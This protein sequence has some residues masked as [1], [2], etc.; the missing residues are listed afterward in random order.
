MSNVEKQQQID[1]LWTERQRQIEQKKED[2]S[3]AKETYKSL[4]T[5]TTAFRIEPGANLE[6]MVSLAKLLQSVVQG[7]HNIPAVNSLQCLAMFEE[8]L[9]LECHYRKTRHELPGSV[10]SL[11]DALNK[12]NL[13][14]T[15]D[16]S[17]AKVY[18]KLGKDGKPVVTTK[19]KLF[20]K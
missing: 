12:S 15:S 6:E 7:N 20:N 16:G 4:Q 5:V 11:G 19:K 17:W 9:R 3:V 18:T 10:H 13:G 1:E 8:A 2:V 14:K